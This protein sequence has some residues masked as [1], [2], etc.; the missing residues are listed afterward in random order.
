MSTS[1]SVAVPRVEVKRSWK[2]PGIYVAACVLLLVFA[3]STR[4][5]VTDTPERQ[6]AVLRDP[7]HCRPPGAPI[8]VGAC[9]R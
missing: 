9:V 8:G 3:L 1:E 7:R 6:V 2:L 5:D 4:G